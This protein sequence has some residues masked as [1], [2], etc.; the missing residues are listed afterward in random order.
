VIR[1]VVPIMIAALAACA[2]PRPTGLAQG[3]AAYQVMPPAPASPAPAVARALEPGDTIAV[4]VFREPDFGIDKMVIDEV[5]NVQLPVLG[6]VH[7]AGLT[8]SGLSAAIADRLG[9]RYLRNPRVTVALLGT[10]PRTV[11]V[12]GQVATPGIFPLARNETLLTSLARAGSPTQ[13]AKLDE[14]VVFRTVNG[15]RMGAVFDVR[16]IRTGGAPDPQIL[17][18]DLVVVGY[19]QLKG[20]YRDFLMATPLLNLF[21]VF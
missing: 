21:T 6:E 17:D 12:E 10:V 11:T 18:G 9:E 19:S 3:A 7:A 2:G 15:Q 4:Q 8:P 1:F 16:Q 14:V 5:G 13:L 20:A